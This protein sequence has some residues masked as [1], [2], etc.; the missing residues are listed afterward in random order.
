MYYV[1]L[2]II[3]YFSLFSAVLILKALTTPFYAPGLNS[4]PN[5]DDRGGRNIQDDVRQIDANAKKKGW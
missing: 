4:N 2:V 5:L 3:A 1:L